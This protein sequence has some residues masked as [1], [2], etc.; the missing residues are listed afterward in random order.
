MDTE[1]PGLSTLAADA[2]EAARV[3]A[4]LGAAARAAAL[5][6]L[7]RELAASRDAIETANRLDKEAAKAAG[8]GA[9][10]ARRLDVEGPKFEDM[11]SKVDDVISI[12]DPVGAVQLAT[13]L[14]SGLNLYRVACPIGV[15]CVIF[16]SRPEAAVQIA[17]LALKSANAVILKGGKEAVHT[18]AALVSAM[19]RALVGLEKAAPA[20]A[21][22]SPPPAAIQLVATRDEVGALLA[23]HGQI[24]LVIPRGSNA[25]VSNIM[26]ST[27][28]PVMGHADGICSVY[29][30]S[31][32][33]ASVAAR[34][35]VDSK[36]NYPVACNAAETLLLHE[37]TMRSSTWPTVA[38]ALVDA[39]VALRC[40]S[41]S[42]S[43]L[44]Q[45]AGEVLRHAIAGGKIVPA[46]DEDFSTEFLALTMAV[47]ALARGPGLRVGVWVGKADDV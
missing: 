15:L 13:K 29:L 16:E 33:D 4:G 12:S 19:R 32:A 44:E 11:L 36:T 17:S 7:R 42:L 6:A 38:T 1:A 39:G 18:N 34:V 45:S 2:R 40:D 31:A 27:R 35:V 14:D 8:L 41:A 26:N 30:H 46:K 3:M 24:D 28:I 47:R 23:L 43:A 20:G 21:A 25:L 9:P 10:L 22:S 37:D 5:H